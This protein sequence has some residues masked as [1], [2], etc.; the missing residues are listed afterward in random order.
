MSWKE[1]LEADARL[2]AK[3]A[4][5]IR[6]ALKQSVNSKT[7]FEAYQATQPQSTGNLA[8]TRA[9]ARAWAI[10]NVRVNMETLKLILLQVWAT[11]FLLGDAAAAEQIAEARRRSQRKS[12][13]INK[14][15]A[16]VA[17]EID[18]ATWKP[19]DQVSA[20]LL[21]PPRAFQRLL[22]QQGITIKEITNTTLKDI[23][24]AI[25]EAVELGLSARQAAGLINRSVA[26]PSRALM[27]A[28]TESNRAMSAA[29]AA[30]YQQAGLEQM[31]WTTFDPCEICASNDGTVVQIGA[32]FPSGHTRPPAHPHCRCAL[33]PVIPGFESS[34]NNTQGGFIDVP[35]V[36]PVRQEQPRYADLWDRKSKPDQLRGTTATAR[37]F[38]K[39]YEG[40]RPPLASANALR[41]YQE[42]TF[43]EMNKRLR[44]GEAPT[45]SVLAM[46][47]LF[48]TAPQI[49]AERTLEYYRVT[50]SEVFEGL[51]EGDIFIDRGFTSAS[52][53]AEEAIR[54]G[55]ESMYDAKVR[56]IDVAN[57]PKVWVDAITQAE[58]LSQGEVV[59]KRGTGFTYVGKDKNGFYVLITA[60]GN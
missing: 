16:D 29:T 4:V 35:A 30:R 46:D 1:P 2:A 57:R 47:K 18:W 48:E 38:D 56:I 9:R 24:N 11:G 22:E 17:V 36:E 34:P 59:F 5:K 25:G 49:K 41:D 27:I 6:A 7:I 15:E 33:L 14:A 8:Q 3:N 52:I 55:E 53:S 44:A 45:D 21:K 40:Y 39:A 13:Q 51:K 28:I 42:T 54:F 43:F 23:G 50:E 32:A 10:I 60:R 37:A 19:G 26:N 12:A 31:E 58:G 20:L